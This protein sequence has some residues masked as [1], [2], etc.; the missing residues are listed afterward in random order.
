MNTA[1]HVWGE[2]NVT[3]GDFRGN[4]FISCTELDSVTPVSSTIMD[5]NVFYDTPER[6]FNGTGTNTTKTVTTRANSTS[7]SVNNIVYPNVLNNYLYM[8]SA[9]TTG[10]SHSS[11]PTWP[12]VLGATVVDGGVTWQAIRGPYTFYRKLLTSPEAYTI[13]YAR[14]HTSAPE[15]GF[16]VSTFAS[17]NDIGI[18]DSEP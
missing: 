10:I 4:V 12:T 15:N 5:F 18:D 13:P 17:R 7:Y 6:T 9:V 14:V 8:A 11:P 16:L 1:Q 2:W 3:D